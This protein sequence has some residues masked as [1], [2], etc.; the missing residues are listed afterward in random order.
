[1][2]MKRHKFGYTTLRDFCRAKDAKNKKDKQHPE[3]KYLQCMTQMN[4]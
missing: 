1:M 2:K 3:R 4:N